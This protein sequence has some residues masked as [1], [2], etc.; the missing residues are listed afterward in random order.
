MK[1][2]LALFS[3]SILL[4]ACY[5]GIDGD[6]G[7][8]AAGDD[9]GGDDVADPGDDGDD[10]PPDPDE[11]APEAPFEV[12][13]AEVEVLP[14]HVR[15]QNLAAVAG[16]KTDHPMFLG[17]YA[18]RYQLGDHDFAT[19]VAPNLKWTPEHME[20]WVKGLRPYCDDPAFQA[21]YPEL[22]TDPTAL[23][24]AAFARDPDGEE[25]AA[26]ADVTAGQIDGAGRHRM[27]CLAVLTSLD[28]VAR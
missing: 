22:A 15:I 7:A 26:F 21:R 8:P 11:P 16:V 3:S 17:L 24:R 19:G 18:K 25:L 27:V 5:Q 6:R 13:N 10:P 2:R 9:A 1:I 28:F 14:F 12:P 20:A 23:V 4:T